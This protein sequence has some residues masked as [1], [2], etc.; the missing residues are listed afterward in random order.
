MV[1]GAAFISESKIRR[2]HVIAKRT[3]N[4]GGL[5][6]GIFVPQKPKALIQE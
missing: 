4:V 1:L 6:I 2:V 3:F 5:G